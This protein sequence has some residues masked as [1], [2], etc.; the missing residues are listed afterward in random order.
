M[1]RRVKPP[2]MRLGRRIKQNETFKVKVRFEHPSFTGLGRVDPETAPRFNRAEPVSFIRNMLVYYGDVVIPTPA[3]VSYAPQ[4]KI[5]G[6]NVD[7]IHTDSANR[8]LL[9]W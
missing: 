9:T 1:A 3:W 5:I 4:A 7:F 8:W 2:R 6:R